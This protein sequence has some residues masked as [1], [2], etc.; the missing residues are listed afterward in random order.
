MARD[1]RVGNCWSQPRRS[2][3]AKNR[4]G[5]SRGLVTNHLGELDD[6]V[7]VLSCGG[8]NRQKHEDWPNSRTLSNRESYSSSDCCLK[9]GRVQCSCLWPKNP[10]AE[11]PKKNTRNFGPPFNH[12]TLPYENKPLWPDKNASNRCYQ[13]NKMLEEFILD[14]SE[15]GLLN[16]YDIPIDVPKRH[17]VRNV[18]KVKT[19]SII[20][21]L[22]ELASGATD[23]EDEGGFSS[24]VSESAVLNRYV[25]KPRA[26]HIR[27]S[28]PRR[29][30]VPKFNYFNSPNFGIDNHINKT[31]FTA[32]PVK[33][34]YDALN[35]FNG[36]NF[37]DDG[38]F[39]C[40]SLKRTLKY[41]RKAVSTHVEEDPRN[42][43]HVQDAC[44]EDEVL[45]QCFS[46]SEV[47]DV[48]QQWIPF[49]KD[50]ID[51]SP[52]TKSKSLL[53]VIDPVVKAPSNKPESLFQN[54]TKAAVPNW[55]QEVFTAAKKGDAEK[56]KWALKD[57]DP[58][59]VRNLS[60]DH[61][62]NLWHICAAHNNFECLS[63]LCSYNQ[64]HVDALKDENKNGFSPVALAIKHGSLLAVKWLIQNTISKTQLLQQTDS[65]SLLHVAARYGQD[66]IVEW[67]LSYMTAQDFDSN[68]I[69][70]EGNTAL[71]LAAKYGQI[72]CVKALVL[73]SGNLKAKNEHGLKPLDLAV[74]HCKKE[75]CD[76]LVALESCYNLS[77]LNLRQHT[78]VQQLQKENAEIKSY[79][80]EL[81]TLT[82]RL[83]HRQKELVHTITHGN[84][85]QYLNSSDR[86]H[87]KNRFFDDYSQLLS[88][89]MTDEEHNLLMVEDRWKKSRKHV[90]PSENK[91]KPLDILRSQFSHIL[92]KVINQS[93]PIP[94]TPE[95]SD[96][97]WHSEDEEKMPTE[98]PFSNY[99]AAPDVVNSLSPQ[100]SVPYLDTR[101][102]MSKEKLIASSNEPDINCTVKSDS[103][104]LKN[105]PSNTPVKPANRDVNLR[106]FFKQ[107]PNLRQSGE[108]CSVL[109]VLEPSSSD[110]E[111]CSSHKKRL[112]KTYDTEK[113]NEQSS[114][115]SALETLS[116]YSCRPSSS[117]SKASGSHSSSSG[118]H[119]NPFATTNSSY[120]QNTSNHSV[121]ETNTK[122]E[123]E[124]APT[125][126]GEN[127][128]NDDLSRNDNISVEPD[129]IKGTQKKKITSAIGEKEKKTVKDLS[130]DLL[131]TDI[132]GISTDSESLEVDRSFSSA[133]V[134]DSLTPIHNPELP[135]IGTA[136]KKK[137]FLLK[138][139]LKGRWP[140]KAPTRALKNEI[141]PEE[142][143]E[144]YSRSAAADAVSSP[145]SQSITT[146]DNSAKKNYPIKTKVEPKPAVTTP[147]SESSERVDGNRFPATPEQLAQAPI[148]NRRGLL[149]PRRDPPPAP[150]V[151]LGDEEQSHDHSDDDC[152]VNVQ[153]SSLSSC[154]ADSLEASVSLHDSFMGSQTSDLW[155]TS[156]SKTLFRP[157]SSA[158]RVE[159]PSRG[160]ENFSLNKSTSA[161]TEMLSALDSSTAG[162][163]SPA[164][165]EVSKTESAL[166][167][168]SDVSKTES[169]RYLSP[170]GKIE[171]TGHLTVIKV[172]NLEHEEEQNIKETM[173]NESR[174]EAKIKKKS[175]KANSD[176][177]WYEFSD[178]EDIIVPQ[179][180]KAV[181]VS[182]R[183]SSEDEEPIIA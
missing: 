122:D 42:R 110:S 146:P 178:E 43:K 101:R 20:D 57:I 106:M 64:H 79:F 10:Y 103:P 151:S 95:S 165:S 111:E 94:S 129:L 159:S 22:S 68:I 121:S 17:H 82:K 107:N 71:H 26:K 177:P 77:A 76:Y 29:D 69:D 81:L 60:D 40:S 6:I 83:Q 139:A 50:K 59:L 73:H 53:T 44:H 161:S 86:S 23:R 136:I 31:N 154:V 85:T 145:P 132:P 148:R 168:P 108:T 98:Q 181:T 172:S 102:K 160:E 84:S 125:S 46:D 124:K 183:S 33:P 5:C 173:S 134:P 72:A 113:E 155:H 135:I 87:V 49:K 119:P 9:N 70:P 38:N 47:K 88:T 32:P 30:R 180:Y 2:A 179:R 182:M 99:L 28:A 65:C 4:P 150:P 130:S 171:E 133:D 114:S 93:P 96:G 63:W 56:M 45:R 137:S 66:A 48:P 149:P 52:R 61:G 153:K 166:S 36:Q 144:T 89:V 140:S 3:P 174:T 7:N 37:I 51:L 115:S 39:T 58:A 167:P 62:N 80:K 175:K 8:R 105:L 131:L 1:E 127:E 19:V 14:D 13:D 92:D 138:F 25:Y 162:R 176:K 74:K 158:S 18:G 104:N 91:K 27:Q 67:L 21:T 54:R 142:F 15:L 157:A 128:S 169:T 75:C 126:M 141:S 11:H 147:E 120:P 170:L 90:K 116:P 97:S 41:L 16:Y 123:S 55:I 12:G 156:D 34:Q 163:Q 112:A 164:P 117:G 78:E 35:N 143:R 100:T 24:A 118:I 152:S 109:E